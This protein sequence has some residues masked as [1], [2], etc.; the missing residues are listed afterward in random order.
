MLSTVRQMISDVRN[1]L[2]TINLDDWISGKYIHSKLIDTTSLFLKREADE[3]RLFLYPDIWTTIQKFDLTGGTLVSCSSIDIPQCDTIM[4]SLQKLPKVF[5]NRYGYFLQ[6]NSIDYDRNYTQITP[7]R[8]KK[9]M[10]RRYRDPNKRYFWIY[11]DYIVIPNCNVESITVRGLFVNKAEALRIDNCDD[12][13]DCGPSACIS[14]LDQT[15]PAPPHLIEEIKDY[16]VKA[17]AGTRKSIH[18]DQYANLNS[19]EKD[20]K[21]SKG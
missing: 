17:I 6:I 7:E 5:T 20:S 9:D 18:A 12:C 16:T 3:R 11:N 1:S 2:N 21:V 15:F 8:Y 19:D 4:I 10:S 14:M 13:D